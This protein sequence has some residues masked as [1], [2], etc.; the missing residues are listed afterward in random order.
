MKIALK[1]FTVLM[2]VLCFSISVKANENMLHLPGSAPEIDELNIITEIYPPYNFKYNGTLYGI[3]VDIMVT[4][5]RKVG[6][7]QTRKDFKLWPWARGYREVLDNKKACLFSTTRT[8]E[9][10][11]LF[12]WV[13][14]IS[15]TTVSVFA[16]KDKKIKIN[17]IKDMQKY[18]IGSVIDDI[19][20]QLIVSNGIKLNALERM[21]GVDVIV[22]SLKKLKKD[23]IDLFSYEENAVKWE[24]K[25]KKFDANEFEV[26]YTLKEGEVYYVFNRDISDS[27]INKLQNALDEIKKDGTYQK[28]LDK[29]L[30]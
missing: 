25:T 13:G 11:N 28:I 26:V 22:N 3:S 24:I 6:S 4:L 16:R 18:R 21:G 17:R 14:P 12:K 29:Y 10:E 7:K 20:E 23:R 9:R 15:P 5:L 8:K 27:I 2:I 30:K 1:Y 19:G